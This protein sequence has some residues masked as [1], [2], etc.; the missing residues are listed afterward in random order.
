[1]NVFTIV[2]TMIV[3]G[4]MTYGIAEFT[5]THPGVIVAIAGVLFGGIVAADSY[6]YG[7][8]NV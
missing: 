8:K 2:A 3:G 5:G 4:L 6:F 1:M 7:T